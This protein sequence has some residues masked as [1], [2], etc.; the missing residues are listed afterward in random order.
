MKRTLSILAFI[1]SILMLIP[2]AALVSFADD[3]DEL[4]T[5]ATL[6]GTP[7]L[8][9]IGNQ[10]EVGCCASMAITYMQFTNAVSKYLREVDPG[11]GP[12]AGLPDGHLC[13]RSGCVGDP[14][15]SAEPGRQSAPGV[16]PAEL[17]AF[18]A[19]YRDCRAGSRLHLC[20]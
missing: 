5:Y 20:L 8:P 17:V 16:F 6:V 1:L 4:P 12:S 9:P 19:R 14:V 10:G 2:A 3:E 15:L 11:D 18:R 13:R 7:D